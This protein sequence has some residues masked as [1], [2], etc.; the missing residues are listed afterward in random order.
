MAHIVRFRLIGLTPYSQSRRHETERIDGESNDDY[1]RRTWR[2]QLHVNGN[3]GVFIPPGAIKGC[4]DEAAKFMAIALPGRG[5]KALYTKHIEAG[6]SCTQPVDIGVKV[7]DVIC[8]ELF[9][10]PTGKPRD[11]KQIKK[12]CTRIDRWSGDAELLIFDDIVLNTMKD[13][14]RTVLQACIE[15]GGTFIGIGRFRPKNRGFYGRFKIENFRVEA[16]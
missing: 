16:V 14:E 7:E 5:G 1:S 11:G 13:Q 2:N 15:G 6:V 9:L 10:S 4:V 3:G 8:E 12:Y